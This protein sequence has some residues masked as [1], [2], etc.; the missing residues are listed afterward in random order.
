ME[1]QLWSISKR[2]FSEE[3]KVTSATGKL[4]SNALM[5]TDEDRI[6]YYSFR[7]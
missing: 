2:N 1:G 6:V 7:K 4:S 5:N 3:T